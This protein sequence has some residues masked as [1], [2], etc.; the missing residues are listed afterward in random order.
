MNQIC[1]FEIEVDD[2]ERAIGFY[3]SVFGWR[4]EK[5]QNSSLDYWE[6]QC[7]PTASEE[8]PEQSLAGLLPFGGMLRRHVA[9]PAAGS[10]ANA[11]VTTI[12]VEDW[13]TTA[14]KIIAAAGQEVVA[15]F[16]VIGRGWQGYFR[17]S[18]ANLLG[19]FQIDPSAQ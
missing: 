18:E 8:Q 13:H 12:L 16:P 17:D 3:S 5:R 6:V 11:H 9:R 10:G 19:I 4:F 2:P 1:Y 15:K 7:A 14:Q